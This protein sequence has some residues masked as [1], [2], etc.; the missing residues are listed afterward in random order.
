MYEEALDNLHGS[1][2]WPGNL[3]TWV[4]A[5]GRYVRVEVKLG[6]FEWGLRVRSG[7]G[8][9]GVDVGG[10]GAGGGGRDSFREV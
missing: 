8:W 7:L 4:V 1:V 5:W 10:A 2:L 9:E 3:L 6:V